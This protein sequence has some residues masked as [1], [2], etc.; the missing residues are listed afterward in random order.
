MLVHRKMLTK[1]KF[2][3][4]NRKKSPVASMQQRA[5]GIG[6]SESAKGIAQRLSPLGGWCT[7]CPMQ[8]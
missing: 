4:D 6:G 1:G 3:D 5:N 2:I 7:S 8:V